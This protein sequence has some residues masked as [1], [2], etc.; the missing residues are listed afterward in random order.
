MLNLPKRLLQFLLPSQC[1]VCERFLEVEQE[2]FCP[3]CFS[4]IRWIGPPFCT[5]CGMP[6]PSEEIESH[7]CGPCLT[8]KKYFTMARASGS[9]EGP[10]REAIHRWKYEGRDNL[11]PFLGEILVGTFHRYWDVSSFDLLLPV[12][13]HPKRLRER[14]FNQA[15]LLAKHLHR[16]TRIPYK[17]GLLRKRIATPPQI[18]LSGKEREKAVKGSFVI[19]DEEAIEGRRILLID[20]VYTTGATVNECSKLLRRGGAERVDVLTLAHALKRS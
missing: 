10:L 14:G 4:Q 18:Q 12:P 2:G 11:T 16:R 6:F 5:C 15:L 1:V 8:E 7:L 9:Y 13:L 17:K 20:D 3:E 19:R